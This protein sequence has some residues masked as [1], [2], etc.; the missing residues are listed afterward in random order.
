MKLNL[1]AV[2]SIIAAGAMMAGDA[3]AQ[4][5]V[6]HM[7]QTRDMIASALE[8][9][10]DVAPQAIGDLDTGYNPIAPCRVADT[11]SALDGGLAAG[12]TR[13]FLLDGDLSGQGGD[14][15]G[16]DIPV[17][18][19]SV[20]LN[21]TVV[22]PEGPAG[23]GGF[24]TAFPGGTE[25]PATATVNYTTGAIIGNGTLIAVGEGVDVYSFRATDVVVDVTGYFADLAP[26]E[27]DCF[28]TQN[29]PYLAAAGEI[30]TDFAFC[31]EGYATVGGACDQNAQMPSLGSGTFSDLDAHVCV[32]DNTASA[33]DAAAFVDTACCRVQPTVATPTVAE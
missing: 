5:A 21:V 19:S 2:T 15:A 3:N 18:A 26:N 31:P 1:I 10:G 25:L 11:R 23:G 24:L 16:C 32:F 30:F 14:A 20:S 22:N 17:E 33:T 27:L 4:R 8:A 12:E 6:G 7:Q 13:N 29:E 9:R 28:T